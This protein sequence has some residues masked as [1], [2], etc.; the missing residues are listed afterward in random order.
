MPRFGLLNNLTSAI[1]IN[2]HPKTTV[3]AQSHELQEVDP[4]SSFRKSL[5]SRQSEQKAIN[6]IH[7]FKIRLIDSAEILKGVWRWW[8]MSIWMVNDRRKACYVP[9]WDEFN[10]L[11][12]LMR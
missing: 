1:R 12:C 11:G 4:S 6:S 8:Q 2:N 10:R 3:P 7:D 9:M 5:S